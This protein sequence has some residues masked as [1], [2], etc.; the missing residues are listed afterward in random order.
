MIVSIKNLFISFLD[1]FEN[2]LYL[3]RILETIC[4]CKLSAWRIVTWSYN[5]TLCGWSAKQTIP[6][7]VLVWNQ[8]KGLDSRSPTR[9]EVGEERQVWEKPGQ[10]AEE[11]REGELAKGDAERQSI[12]D[13]RRDQSGSV[14]SP[15]W[16]MV[17]RRK[18]WGKTSHDELAFLVAL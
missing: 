8:T 4:L 2:Y 12:T 15:E 17:S 14:S 11:S 3:I 7:S 1:L 18:Q 6:L 9:P 13:S 10:L 16:T 5:V